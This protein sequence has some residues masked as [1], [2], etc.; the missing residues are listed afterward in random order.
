MPEPVTAITAGVTIFSG[1]MQSK[2]Q[3][4]AAATAA[5]AQTAAGQAA[6]AE[7][8]R[9]FERTQELLE[10]YTAAGERALADQEAL[11]GLK[12]PQAQQEAIAAIET[13]PE[14]ASFTRQGEEA[15]LAQASATGGLRGGDV[16][17]ALSQFRPDLL[18]ELINQRF[19]RLGGIA[20][21]GQTA[22]A[23]VGTAGI[24]TGMN[25][26]NI[27]LGIGE[28]Q[29]GQAIAG[30]QANIGLINA[31]SQATGQITGGF[32]NR[33]GVTIPRPTPHGPEDRGGF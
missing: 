22:A 21:R 20:G 31:L 33:G 16:Q 13:S 28:A 29:A 19:A 9:Q 1:Y 11:L 27:Q 7:N 26:G 12:G 8:R 24:Q 30:G 10:P 2:A 17:G 15:I 25:I 14:F 3:K 23:G 18:N 32:I 4:D 5:G 6:I